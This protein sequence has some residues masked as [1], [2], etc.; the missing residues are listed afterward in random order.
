MFLHL[1]SLVFH[2]IVKISSKCISLKSIK[3][4]YFKKIYKKYNCILTDEYPI[5]LKAEGDGRFMKL[6]RTFDL[7]LISSNIGLSKLEYF[8]NSN[9]AN[10]SGVKFRLSIA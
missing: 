2:I 4:N 3:I 8:I 1:L 9:T 7:L 10:S 6:I 5:F